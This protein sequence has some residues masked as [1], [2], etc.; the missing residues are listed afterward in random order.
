[1]RRPL[2]LVTLLVLAVAM[3]AARSAEPTPDLTAAHP[4]ASANP[5]AAPSPALFDATSHR[6][7]EDVAHWESIFDDPKR[8]A[9]QKPREVVAALALRPGMRVADVGAGTG[10]FLA[11]LAAAVGPTGA[12]FAVETEPN[13]IVHLRE[14]AERDRLAN[15]VPVLTSFDRLRLP[16]ASV[17]LVLLVDT[18]HHLDARREYLARLRDVLAPDARVAIVDWEKDALAVG[19]PRPHRIARAQVLEEMRLAGYDLVEA[20]DLLTYQYLLV[21]APR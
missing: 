1:M 15:V 10:Y 12:V 17:D 2:G 3:P 21:F 19:P 20:P 11:P 6:T 5:A 16:P 9:W 13:L 7:F 18:Y 4:T 14:R 8:D